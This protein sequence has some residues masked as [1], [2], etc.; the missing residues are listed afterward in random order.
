MKMQTKIYQL[1]Y[2]FSIGYLSSLTLNHKIIKPCGAFCRIGDANVSNLILIIRPTALCNYNFYYSFY[3][4]AR[5]DSVPPN[6]GWA[7]KP[8]G[9]LKS[10]KG[11]VSPLRSTKT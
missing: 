2:A 6:A 9:C 3:A 7:E 4:T 10:H 5:R 8:E 1:L 11:R